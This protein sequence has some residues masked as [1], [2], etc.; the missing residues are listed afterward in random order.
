MKAPVAH[1]SCIGNSLM[2][3][4]PHQ[5]AVSWPSGT[6][7]AGTGAQAAER[8]VCSNSSGRDHLA[9][10]ESGELERLLGLSRGY[11]SRLRDAQ[12]DPSAGLVALLTLLAKK[13]KSRVAELR[14]S[15]Q[16][17]ASEKPAA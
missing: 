15:W 12:R 1:H 13:P 9:I 17:S 14:R 16:A 4:R 2:H 11:L 3:R 7:L 5:T 10:S 6:P 8:R